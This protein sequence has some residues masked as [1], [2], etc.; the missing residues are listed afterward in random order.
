[1]ENDFSITLN[2]LQHFA[3]CQRQWALIFIEGYW[4]DNYKTVEGNIVH[5]LVDDPFFDE[6]R[7]NVRTVRSLP[8]YYDELNLQGIADLVEFTLSPQGAYLKELGGNYQITVVEYKN[9]KPLVSGRINYPDNLQLAA[10]MMCLENM[11]GT[12]CEGYIFYHAIGRRVKLTDKQ[13]SFDNVRKIIQEMKFWANT[14]TIPP[15]PSG[16]KCGNCSLENICMPKTSV[17]TTQR[18]R[19]NRLWESEYAQVT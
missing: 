14:K 2:S 6:R 1:M 8:L 12:P 18:N 7:K 11:F 9:G 13:E 17:K 3:Y 19:I 10:Q 4:L 16:Q 5:T 15:K